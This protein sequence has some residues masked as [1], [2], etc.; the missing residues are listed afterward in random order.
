M[1]NALKHSYEMDIAGRQVIQHRN[2]GTRNF[3]WFSGAVTLRYFIE[4]MNGLQD[5][6]SKQAL[7]STRF[8]AYWDR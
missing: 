1:A 3:A 8:S 2:D 7:L 6:T 4:E 5:E